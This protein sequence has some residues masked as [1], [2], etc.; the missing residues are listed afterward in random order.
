[1]SSLFIPRS[2]SAALAAIAGSGLVG[3]MPLAARY[4]YADGLGAPSMLFWRYVIAILALGAATILAGLNLSRAWRDGAWRIVLLGATLG[5]GQTLCFWESIKTLETSVAV[6][7]FY[8]YPAVTVALDRIVF[9]TR[10]RPLSLWCIGAI[11]FGAALITAPGLHGGHLDPRGLAWALPAP[12]LYAV[13]LAINARLLRRH[14][15]L[16]GAAGLYIG[17]AATFGLMTS[18]LGLDV[19]TSAAGWA[20]LL[21]VGL[22]PGAVTM[23][24]FTYSIPRLGASSFAI[25]ANTEL[26]VV[27]SIGVLVLGEPMTPWRAIGGALILA[28]IVA[29]IVARR[30]TPAPRPAETAAPSATARAE[31]AG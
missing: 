2:W 13:Y 17:M 21:F 7:L 19:P 1:V 27:V 24:L 16:I 5:A 3:V 9:K 6:L 18:W 10:V 25:L 30:P 8:T 20:L 31:P 29:H 22:G 11:L 26:V 4:L 12:L 28:G 14:P 15:P 23:T